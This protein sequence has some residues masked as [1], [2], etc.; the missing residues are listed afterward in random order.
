[1][2]YVTCTIS[3]T[4]TELKFQVQDDRGSSSKDVPFVRDRLAELTVQR[5]SYWVQQDLAQGYKQP[6]TSVKD[7]KA[8]G[9][10]L[11]RLLFG[12]DRIR[13]QFEEQYDDFDR[14]RKNEPDL[15]LR[16]ELVFEQS[17]ESLAA[18][19]WEFLFVA[20]DEDID[21]GVFF[22]GDRT[23]LLLTRRL[24]RGMPD[25]FQPTDE[26]RIL[27]VTCWPQ[28][29]GTVDPGEVNSVVNRLDELN[30]ATSG[31]VRIHRL[32]NPTYSSLRAAIQGNA[33]DVSGKP[34]GRPDILHFIGHGKEG[35]LAL[36]K[37]PEEPD[38]DDTTNEE[39]YRWAEGD[40]VR[41]LFSGHRPRLVFL[42]ACKGAASSSL[43]SFNS[44]ARDLVYEG[45]AAV[46]A[47]Q[48]NISNSDAGLFARKFYEALSK[49]ANIDESVTVARLAF[50]EVFPPLH[51]RFGTPVVYV[52][53]YDPI[54]KAPQ[55]SGVTRP[56]ETTAAA[57]VT[58]RQDVTLGQTRAPAQETSAPAAGARDR[59][60]DP[61]PS[62][63]ED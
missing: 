25:A 58:S 51:P 2:R 54:V 27:V 7:L 26:L 19:P 41:S 55:E 22:A 37:G 10:Q 62:G 9:L 39:Q 46:V 35:A 21:R 42:H 3:F 5:L 4:D 8:I 31:G 14:R 16:L 32:V 11:Y 13:Q 24:A 61:S 28:R 1:M 23:E 36:L 57:R 15:R 38:Y 52:Q 48:Y 30:T 59:R 18:L 33:L 43:E 29:L 49:G 45:I 12:N 6:L 63:L 60:P 56:A 50:R 34:F 44:T 40:Q 53:A 20:K 47:M 17:A